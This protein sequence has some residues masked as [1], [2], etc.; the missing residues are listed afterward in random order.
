LGLVRSDSENNRLDATAGR[1]S[2]KRA[3][4]APRITRSV[5]W[6]PK[7]EN[8]S[9]PRFGGFRWFG[10]QVSVWAA[11]LSVARS[12]IWQPVCL[13]HDLV[14]AGV[15]WSVAQQRRAAA[16]GAWPQGHS[17]SHF[18][19]SE[20]ASDFRAGRTIGRHR[21][22]RRIRPAFSGFFQLWGIRHFPVSLGV[23]CRRIGWPQRSVRRRMA[24]E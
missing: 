21:T 20:R 11:F 5:L 23:D 15:H 1:L 12:G 14:F 7:F 19:V 22:S 2:G 18:A 9:I 6:R 10:V 3:G 13:T 4:V 16:D 24:E 8:P 17:A